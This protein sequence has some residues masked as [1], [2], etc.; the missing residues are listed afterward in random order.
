[1]VGKNGWYGAKCR[2]IITT[3]DTSLL[4]QHGVHTINYEVNELNHKKPLSFLTGGTLNRMFLDPK[5]I[6]KSFH[7][8]L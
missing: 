2:I 4:K 6:L 1:M 7:I 5:K 3:K 8:V